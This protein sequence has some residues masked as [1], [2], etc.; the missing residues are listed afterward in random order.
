MKV[1]ILQSNYVPWKGYF[2]LIQEADFFVFY[3]CVKYTKNDWRNRNQ[4]YPKSGKQWL[5]IPIAASAVNQSIDEV[6][7]TDLKWQEQHF[8]TLYFGYKKAPYFAQL[9]ELLVDYLQQK[10]WT[11]LSELNH[12]LIKTISQKMGIKTTFRNAREFDLTG[13]RVE[14]LVNIVS[15]LGG[16]AY[17]SGLAAQDY[18]AGKEHLFSDTKIELRFKHYPV[19]PA[20]QQSTMPFEQYVS[21][22][23]LIA[24]LH[25]DDIQNYIW[26]I[27]KLEN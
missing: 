24:N 16:T 6:K 8:K 2:D 10:K 9:E 22:L 27:S 5:T 11:M 19:Y 17:I 23:D 21:I 13:N 14:R 26:R 18:L 20:Y 12:Y 3:D 7:L 25:W 4:I 15:A 1:V